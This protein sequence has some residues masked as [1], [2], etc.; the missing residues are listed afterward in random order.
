MLPRWSTSAY[1]TTPNRNTG[2]FIAGTGTGGL[3]SIFSISSSVS[4]HERLRTRA[5]LTN[6][7]VGLILLA[8]AL[9]LLANISHYIGEPDASAWRMGRTGKPRWREQL[10]RLAVLSGNDRGMAAYGETDVPLS[11]ETTIER[12]DGLQELDHLVMVAAH[13]I[14]KG[15]DA[16]LREHDDDWILQTIQR[17]GSV[18]TFYK[19][20]ARGVEEAL[21][22][23]HS[24]LVFSGGQTRPDAPPTT[25]AQSYLRLA[26]DSGLLPPPPEF[27]RATTE[28]F[29]LD[30]YTNV[31]FSLARFKEVTG[32]WPSRMTVVGF[33]MKRPRFERLHRAAIKFPEDK[34]TYIGID[35]EGDT[36]ASYEGELK[37]GYQPFTEDPYGCFPPLSLKRLSRNPFMRY[38]PYHSST[39]ELAGLLE[40]CPDHKI[41]PEAG[42]PSLDGL[43]PLRLPWEETPP[44]P[45]WEREQD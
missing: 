36:R 37:Y 5:R 34:F 10:D 16:T 33:E 31:L 27:I 25:E 6:L 21:K 29:A 7:A 19:H 14:W 9:S 15:T 30:S 26:L 42:K 40:W 3:S 18:K 24:L 45:R 22:D 2:R 17:G 35:D 20:V 44:P 4:L 38:H 32:R 11:I 8:L 23:P 41:Q 39:P 43:Y 28:D 13:A 12:Q 1:R